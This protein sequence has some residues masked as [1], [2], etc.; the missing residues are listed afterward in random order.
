MWRRSIVVL[1]IMVG[2]CFSAILGKLVMLQIVETEEWQKLAVGQQMQDN[3]TSPKRGMIYDANM[4]ELAKTVTVWTVIMSPRDIGSADSERDPEAYAKQEALRNKIADEV[5]A[6]LEVDRDKLYQK[7]KKTNSAYEI[8]KSKISYADKQ[9]VS[10]WVLEN[11]LTNVFSLVEDYK[12]TYPSKTLLSSVLG[13]IGTDNY[14]LSGLEAEY[15]KVLAGKP[16]R[17]ITAKNGWG[18][19]MPNTMRYEKTVDAQTGNSLVLTID[20]T[21][22]NFAEKY[23][24][25]AVKSTGATN[26]GCAIVMEVNTGAILAMATKGDFDPNEPFIIQDPDT[27]AAIALLSG[28]DRSK[29][30]NEALQKQW[31][32]KPITEFYEPGSVFKVFTSCM[33]VEEGIAKDGSRY[34][35]TNGLHVGGEFI[36]CHIYPRG[37]GS[38]T[39]AEAISH[40]CNQAFGSLGMQIGAKLFYKYYS[41]FGFT[42]RTDIDMLGEERV[43]SVLYHTESQLGE[44][45]LATSAIG[46]TFKVTPIQMI[47]AM[48]AV[49]NGGKLMQ[50]YVVS[51]IVDENGKV[52]QTTKPTVKRQVISE[53]TAKKVSAMLAEAVNGGGSKNAY[54]AGYRVAGKTG[55]SDKTDQ[56][57]PDGRN[58]VVASFSGFAPADDAQ[59]AVLVM[60]D[61]PQCAVRYGGTISAPVAQEILASALPYLGVEPKY[62]EEEIANMND[63]TPKVDGKEISVAEN[64]I[65]SKGLQ[66]KVVGSGATVTRQVPSGGQ[67]IPK[68]GMVVLYT[69]G[70]DTSKMATVPDFSGRTLGEANQAAANAGLNIQLNINAASNQSEGGEARASEQSVKAGEQVPIGTVISVKFIYRDNIE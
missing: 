11:S 44:L 46:Q 7:T 14:G 63:T 15:D 2:F 34:T 27:Q 35:C 39:L 13:F 47:T 31:K 16:G 24:E 64:M 4:K 1:V 3:V 59:V 23:L 40:S 21:V 25:V 68:G 45:D 43:S 42:A 32:N 62:T 29:A 70:D 56:K 17:V 6:L 55:T 54:V 26:R 19:E 28:D 38:Q 53:A 60:L 12:R 58:N 57:L 65:K 33:A 36:K 41:G 50:P 48:S 30:V 37:H 51:Q 18:D 9:M 8:V 52:V 67:A 10:D 5:S 61:E 22:Q 20:Q 66:C 49:A 69:D